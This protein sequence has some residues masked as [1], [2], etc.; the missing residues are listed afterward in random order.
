MD[1]QLPALRQVVA[2]NEG[3][4]LHVKTSSP[5]IGGDQH[6]A[7]PSTEF[8]HNGI[9]LFLRH[10]TVHAAYCKIGLLHL[11]REGFSLLALIA[12]NYRLSYCE[13]IIKVAE[14]LEL[15]FILFHSDKELF[16]AVEG[17]F[18]TLNQDLHGLVH[19]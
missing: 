3:D 6:S 14:G 5:D 4:L 8:L 1:I 17:Q 16:Y 2:D 18:I 13:R 9:S 12:E 10:S 11:F 7:G 19:K 15:V